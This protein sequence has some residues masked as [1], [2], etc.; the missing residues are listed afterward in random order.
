MATDT[1]Q[2]STPVSIPGLSWD[3]WNLSADAQAVARAR[4]PHL[5]A[6][7][8]GT[9]ESCPARYMAER[10]LPRTEDPFGAAELGTSGHEVFEALFSLP[11]DQRTK[12]AARQFVNEQALA[13]N[14][15]GTPLQPF[16][17]GDSDLDRLLTLAWKAQVWRRVQGLWK[18]EDPTRIVVRRT[19]W[20][21]EGI[22]LNG[23]IFKGFI[24]RVDIVED[25][26]GV[27][28]QV[29]DF[30]C[31]KA[32]TYVPPS[33]TDSYADQIRLYAAA[34]RAWDGH[35]PLTGKLYFTAHGLVREIDLSRSKIDDTLARFKRAND[36]VREAE[37]TGLY[38]T[39]ESA[40]CGWCHLVASCPTAAAAGKEAA[41]VNESVIVL[42]VSAPPV[43]ES[44]D[45]RDPETPAAHESGDPETAIKEQL[46]SDI[47][48]VDVLV[49]D[50]PWEPTSGPDRNLNPNSYSA[51]AAFGIVS[52]AVDTLHRHDQEITGTTVNALAATFAHVVADVQ[53]QLAG[54]VTLQAGLHTRLRGALHT[55]V[56]SL[57]IP[58]GESTDE[59]D[60]WVD[61]ATRRV[62]AIAKAA[63]RL[64]SH[65]AGD[66]PW[67]ALGVDELPVEDDFAA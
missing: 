66:S 50:K 31:G 42:P 32:K 37:E 13:L 43:E 51:T 52:M 14:R 61:D 25:E 4:K 38:P 53:E 19:E 35:L 55:T 26:H 58:F 49:E 2:T 30:K 36:T 40:L 6:S 18:I 46:M 45:T 56:N 12:E 67:S 24:D 10:Q 41:P 16:V 8:M 33:W 5:S 39:K 48:P 7:A 65:G 17:H 44:D 15:D 59:W 34:V 47:A 54:E 11:H 27:G 9:I 1:D 63:I 3:G 21:L 20:H 57:P 29:V 60:R 23:V 64:W 22:E 62:R 28:V